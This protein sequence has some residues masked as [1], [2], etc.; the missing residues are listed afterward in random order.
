MNS[1]IE[2]Y[3]PLFEYYQALRAQL[4]EIISDDD[5][6]FQ[7]P[8][9]SQ[10]L[11]FLCKQVGEV[12]YS[13]IQSFKNFQQDWSYKNEDPELEASA[14]KLTSWYTDLDRDLRTAIEALSEDDIQTR[15][16]D[17]GDG[18]SASPRAQL[19]I[20]KEALL[21]FYGKVSVYLKIRGIPLPEQWADW[22]T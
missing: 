3:Y 21:I 7:P 9:G 4:M 1:I 13:Y 20:Y 19:E 17:R 10:T 5:L 6:A 14:A 18:F 15:T 22:I 2:N 16:I 12:Q 8:G 11:G